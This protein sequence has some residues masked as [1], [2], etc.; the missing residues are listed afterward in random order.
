MEFGLNG[1]KGTT[2]VSGDMAQ[3]VSIPKARLEKLRKKATA[4][5]RLAKKMASHAMTA[6]EDSLA[7]DWLSK[8][9][10]DAWKDL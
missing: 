5:D 3:T 9:E 2:S 7:K 4:F 10:E 1:S 6:S 8:E